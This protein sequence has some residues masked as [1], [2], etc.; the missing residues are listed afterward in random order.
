MS[1]EIL[2]N[3]TVKSHTGA[4]R[5]VSQQGKRK[6]S[7][8]PSPILATDMYINVIF[9]LYDIYVSF[10]KYF[11]LNFEHDKRQTTFYLIYER[12]EIRVF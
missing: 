11:S 1:L 5:K 4:E 7:C 3:F 2:A 9:T 8:D 6:K 12:A 10:I